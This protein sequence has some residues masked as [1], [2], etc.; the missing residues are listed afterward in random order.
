MT[1][2]PCH[3]LPPGKWHLQHGTS[4]GG[5]RPGPPYSNNTV[6]QTNPVSNVLAAAPTCSCH[7]TANRTTPAN[8][9]TA[10]HTV[11]RQGSTPATIAALSGCCCTGPYTR[12]RCA[13]TGK[14]AREQSSRRG[15]GR[16]PDRACQHQHTCTASFKGEVLP[17]CQSE[18]EK[19]RCQA[20]VLCVPTTPTCHI[21]SRT[22]PRHHQPLSLSLSLSLHM[23][24]CAVCPS[25]SHLPHHVPDEPAGRQHL[26]VGQDDPLLLLLQTPEVKHTL[27]QQQQ[28]HNRTAHTAQ[29]GTA[30]HEQGGQEQWYGSIGALSRLL[31]PVPPTRTPYSPTA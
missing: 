14:A 31:R 3:Y 5:T 9:V 10:S 13:Y 29:H 23:S 4:R 11:Q 28:G 20:R 7:C 22:V 2:Q 21:M 17:P 26:A 18:S 6:C 24:S 8:A 15:V 30:Q 27:R 16:T 1:C 25:Q 12:A 19:N